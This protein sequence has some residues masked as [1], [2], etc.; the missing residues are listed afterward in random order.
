MEGESCMLRIRHPAAL[1]RGAGLLSRPSAWF[2]AAVAPVPQAEVPAG[3]CFTT[4]G[5]IAE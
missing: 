4:K 1:C 5:L 2:A 3:L